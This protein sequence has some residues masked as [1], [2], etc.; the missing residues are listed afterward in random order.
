MHL[1]QSDQSSFPFEPPKLLPFPEPE[2]SAQNAATQAAQVYDHYPWK[3]G[4]PVAL[5]AIE[6]A[7]RNHGFEHVLARTIR[8]E[9][10]RGPTRHEAPR[11]PNPSTWFNQ[12]R[13]NDDEETWLPF[14]ETTPT[15]AKQRDMAAQ[16]AEK[17]P[18]GWELFARMSPDRCQYEKDYKHAPDFMKKD[19]EKWRA[20]R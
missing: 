5:K 7:I 2:K 9:E 17:A 20:A 10:L 8:Y 16:A 14:E 13:F 12:E 11:P 6:K 4:R 19:F 3:T 15:P 1:P 18:E